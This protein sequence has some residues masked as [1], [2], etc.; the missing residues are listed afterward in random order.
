MAH[1]ASTGIVLL[2]L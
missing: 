2:F 1:R